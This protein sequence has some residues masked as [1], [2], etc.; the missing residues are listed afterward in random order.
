MTIDQL[1]GAP[2]A[3]SSANAGT[4]LPYL[5]ET[6]S[7]YNIITP[8]RQLCFLSQIGHESAGLYYTEELASGGA[9]EGRTDLGNTETGDGRKF[10]GRGLIQITGRG[11]YKALSKEFGVDFVKNP[12]LLGGKN[13][14]VSTSDQIRY[15]VLSAGWFW[16]QKNLNSFA[17]KID[18]SKPIDEGENYNNFKQITRKI[19]GGL[20]G[21]QD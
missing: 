18:L 17:D 3:K 10:K 15:S 16:N 2:M 6:F 21:L 12:E 13:L 5:E 7:K 19:N 9:Y 14:G 8:V 4:L 20:N 11:N 1:K